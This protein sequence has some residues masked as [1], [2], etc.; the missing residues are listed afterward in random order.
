[1]RAK[2]VC[3]TYVNMRSC[4]KLTCIIIL[5]R[6]ADI[7]EQEVTLLRD[8]IDLFPHYNDLDFEHLSPV[9]R[10]AASELILRLRNFEQQAIHEFESVLVSE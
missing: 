1:M 9:I 6:A 4:W 3:D 10:K 8:R 5:S 2:P 7:Y